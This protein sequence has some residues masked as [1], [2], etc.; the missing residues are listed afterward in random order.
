V[1]F[2]VVLV[3]TVLLDVWGM[4]P[5]EPVDP[6]VRLAIALLPT[7]AALVGVRI[8]SS[9]GVATDTVAHG[10]RGEHHGSFFSEDDHLILGAVI[11]ELERG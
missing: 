11:N 8:R 3:V 6:R 2:R 5:V 7:H 4:S 9:W 10:R 1:T